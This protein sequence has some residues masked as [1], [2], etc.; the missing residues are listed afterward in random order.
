MHAIAFAVFLFAAPAAPVTGAPTEKQAT[1]LLAKWVA[2]QNAGDADAYQTMYAATF[3]GVRRSGKKATTFDRAGW[4]ADRTKMFKKPM[5]VAATGATVTMAGAK[6]TVR[7]T[8]TWGS[9]SYRDTGTKEI[10]LVLDAAEPRIAREE[11]L[12]SKVLPR[13]LLKWIV[14]PS[15]ERSFDVT[16]VVSGSLKGTFSQGIYDG[17]QA[18]PAGPLEKGKQTEVVCREGD[19]YQAFSAT[20]DGKK[21]TIVETVGSADTGD[22]KDTTVETLAIPSGADVFVEIEMSAPEIP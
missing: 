15:S 3:E 2:A 12:D 14:T 10:V 7:F 6:A 11:M 17:C 20:N 21:L 16:L 9:G 1:D 4:I 13:V 19:A 8:Q 18:P 5:Q 22:A